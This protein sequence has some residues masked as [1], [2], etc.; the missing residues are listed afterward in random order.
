V[1]SMVPSGKLDLISKPTLT[2]TNVTP[3]PEA[4]PAKAEK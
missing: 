2:F 4:A 3:A 1:V